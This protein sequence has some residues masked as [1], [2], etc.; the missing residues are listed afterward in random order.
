MAV[1]L[2]APTSLGTL[3][4]TNH[5]VMAP[6]TRSRAPGNVPN[7]MMAAYYGDRATVGLIITEGTSPSPDGLGYTRIPGA[8]SDAQREGWRLVA[9]AV[10]AKGG[11]IFVQLMHTGRVAHPDNLPAGARVVAPSALAAPGQMHTDAHG[12]QDHPVPHALTTDELPGVIAEYVHAAKNLVAAGIDGV[13]LHGAN[14]YLLEQFLSPASNHRTDAYGGSVENRLRFV[15]EVADAVAKA[16]GGARVG[17]RLSPYGVNGGM[18]STYEGIDA[19]YVQLTERLAATGIQY[20]HVVDHSAMGAPTVPASLKRAMRAAFPRTFILAG[21]FNKE[22]AEVALTE[23][24]ADLIAIGRPL[25]ANP[26]Y[27]A[28]VQKGVA[29]AAVDFSTAYTPGEK[30]YTDYPHAT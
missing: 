27:V 23:G 17:I 5:V 10:H 14:G 12:N 21:G 7:A 13:E 8:F 15:V 22:S 24:Q 30:G 19:A 25:I 11:K 16:I 2:F 3:S 1:S 18:E 9:D 26:D 4:L 20:I 6:M 28:R 29:L